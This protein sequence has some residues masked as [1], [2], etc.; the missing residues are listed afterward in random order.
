MRSMRPGF[1]TSQI[2]AL[3]ACLTKRPRLKAWPRPKV[4]GAALQLRFVQNEI[5][6]FHGKASRSTLPPVRMIPTR[7]PDTTILFSMI[8]AYGTAADGSITIFI[9]SQIVRIDETIASSLT[10]TI[11]S[12]YR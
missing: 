10:V 1:Q 12:T 4:F 9:V 2:I 5:V 7:F 6:G 11:F 3:H 8:A